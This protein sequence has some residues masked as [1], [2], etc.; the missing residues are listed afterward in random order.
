MRI[1]YIGWVGRNNIGDEACYEAIR[2]Y[3]P[4][5]A[6]VIAWDADCWTGPPPD[7]SILG[8]GTL[9]NLAHDRR[10]KALCK[11]QSQNVPTIIWGSG[12]LP[13]EGKRASPQVLSLLRNSAFV[14]VRGPTSKEALIAQ[15]ISK[16]E[17]IGDPGFVY[18][19]FTRR[20]V[21]N[22]IA[23]NIGFARHQMFGSE[24]YL[25]REIKILVPKL[26][27]VGYDVVLFPM[28]PQDIPILEMTGFPSLGFNPSTSELLSLL[29]SCYCTIGM[30]L[31][32]SILSAAALT[33]FVSIAYRD[34]CFDFAKSVGLEKW[35][36]RADTPRLALQIMKHIEM[37]PKYRA[38]I[39]DRLKAY[40]EVYQQRHSI[41][42]T[43]IAN[44]R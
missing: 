34:K 31:H 26:I 10:T 3:L 6:Q 24:E 8:G 4:T 30:K 40:K 35:A 41:F 42:S 22:T 13:F 39:I 36:L 29:S 11:F 1:S 2:T 28:W 5:D 14:G 25:V 12:V 18:E 43:F 20:P 23:I 15:G 9:L 21:T 33:P 16:A 38:V 27:H 44:M 37:L 7:V 17:I 19:K 32:S